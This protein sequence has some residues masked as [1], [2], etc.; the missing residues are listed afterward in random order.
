MSSPKPKKNNQQ[1]FFPQRLDNILNMRHE[2][3]ILTDGID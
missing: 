2:L 1:D 3:V